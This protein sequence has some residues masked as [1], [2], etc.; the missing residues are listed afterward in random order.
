[1]GKSMLKGTNIST[2]KPHLVTVV[3]HLVEPISPKAVDAHDRLSAVEMKQINSTGATSAFAH[4]FLRMLTIQLWQ[5]VEVS[6]MGLKPLPALKEV[7]V[8]FPYTW[9]TT[10]TSF[11]SLSG[12][13]VLTS[14]ISGIPALL[15]ESGTSFLQEKSAADLC[16]YCTEVPSNWRGHMGAHII[17]RLQNAEEIDRNRKENKARIVRVWPEV[18]CFIS[19][20]ARHSSL[21]RSRAFILAASAVIPAILP[22]PSR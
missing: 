1:M 2:D 14:I 8:G 16:L 20:F 10:G 18:C 9:A 21:P 7:L 11:A 15:S 17:R 19:T 13:P 6:K 4:G 12:K 5:R 3:G 22:V